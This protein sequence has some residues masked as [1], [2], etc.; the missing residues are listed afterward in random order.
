MCFQKFRLPSSSSDF[1][2]DIV[3]LQKKR[4]AGDPSRTVEGKAAARVTHSLSD[5]A[6]LA[7]R[8]VRQV[9]S[10]KQRNSVLTILS[11]KAIFLEENLA[12]YPGRLESRNRS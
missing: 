9:Y 11:K 2:A 7:R 5:S 10:C 8:S 6:V 3:G 1:L 4:A 12:Q